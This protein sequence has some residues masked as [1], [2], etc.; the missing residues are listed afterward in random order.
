MEIARPDRLLVRVTWAVMLFAIA[1]C[2]PAFK[3]RLTRLDLP[4]SCPGT[5]EDALAPVNTDPVRATEA[6]LSCALNAVRMMRPPHA[7]ESLE[8]SKICAVLAEGSPNT[9][10]GNKRRRDLAWEG[11]AWAEH[12]MATGAYSDSASSYYY[13]VNMGLAVVDSIMTAMK[14]LGKLHR[15]VE[16]SL[17]LDPDI[18]EGGPLRTLGYLL[19]RAPAWPTGIGDP[20]RGLILLEQAVTLYPAYP[21]NNLYMA[22]GIWEAEEDEESA[23]PFL[24]EAVD[25][26]RTHNWGVRHEAWSRDLRNLINDMYE[27]EEAA[28]LISRMHEP[29]APAN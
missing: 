6:Q 17:S 28:D 22:K 20:D 19:I 13:S 14:N 9:D 21:P 7:F 23:R 26:M 3:G 1:G 27:G 18:D 12:A 5:I 15:N 16:R 2:G 10:E 8:A 11:V 24:D 25:Q 4:E 29:E